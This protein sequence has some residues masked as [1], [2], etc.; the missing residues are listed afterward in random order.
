MDTLQELL[1]R[2]VTSLSEA[3]TQRE[4]ESLTRDGT[5]ER[6]GP[7]TRDIEKPFIPVPV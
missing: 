3:D 6:L 5:L 7:I 4:W 1:P 2:T